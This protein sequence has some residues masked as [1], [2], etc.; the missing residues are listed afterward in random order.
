MTFDAFVYFENT[1]SRQYIVLCVYLAKSGK[2]AIL[3]INIFAEVQ[4]SMDVVFSG[5]RPTG[6][7]HLGH[8]AGALSNWVK[9]QE[10]H[11]CYFSI[12]DWHALM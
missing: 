3:T 12:V 11:E 8:M 10:D 6:R 7:L 5:M 9:L 2:S 1:A 4:V